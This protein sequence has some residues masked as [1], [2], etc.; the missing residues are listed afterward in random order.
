VFRLVLHFFNVLVVVPERFQT[1]CRWVVMGVHCFLVVWDVPGSLQ[2]SS[3]RVPHGF[4]LLSLLLVVP[5]GV[6]RFVF[7]LFPGVV[8]HVFIVLDGLQTNGGQMFIMAPDVFQTSS[9][10]VPD[11]LRGLD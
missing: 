10:R 9:R 4:Q 2:T 11:G 1:R 8:F 5:K 3:R 6:N 7:A